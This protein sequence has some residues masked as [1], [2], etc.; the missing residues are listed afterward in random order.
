MPSGFASQEDGGVAMYG[1]YLLRAQFPEITAPSARGMVGLIHRI[2]A[3]IT[4]PD[5]LEPLRQRCTPDGVSLADFHERITS[6]VLL[7]GR[8]GLLADFDEGTAM[9]YIAGYRALSIINWSKAGDFF[10]LD[11]TAPELDA[12]YEWN[13]RTQF[14]E[15]RLAGGSTR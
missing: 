8:Y 1:A 6:E 2:P 13:D 7:M 12:N 4:L 3:K 15:L 9:P 14:R 10:V 5:K 11:E